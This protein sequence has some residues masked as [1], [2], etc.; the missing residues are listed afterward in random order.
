LLS[1]NASIGYVAFFLSFQPLEPREHLA[2]FG[3][4]P[5]EFDWQAANS[6]TSSGQYPAGRASL[7]STILT[8]GFM[9]VTGIP[10]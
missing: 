4:S 1:S 7:V 5:G 8:G 6:Q 3:D 9:P 2:R 10:R